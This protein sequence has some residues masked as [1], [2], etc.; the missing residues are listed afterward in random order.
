M[1]SDAQKQSDLLDE[2]AVKIMMVE[3]GD[4]SAVGELLELLEKLQ[5]SAGAASSAIL[6]QMAM[7][8]SATNYLTEIPLMM[9]HIYRT[10][11]LYVRYWKKKILFM[12]PIA[13]CAAKTI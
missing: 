13:S 10:G 6:Q 9:S 11:T 4:L 2:I 7:S 12:W 1:S 8:R 5:E 3:P